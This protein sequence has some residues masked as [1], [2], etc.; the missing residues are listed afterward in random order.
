MSP[1]SWVHWADD[2]AGNEA[3]TRTRHGISAAVPV[4]WPCRTA[5]VGFTPRR[6]K[7]PRRPSRKDAVRM[8]GAPSI[9]AELCFTNATGCVFHS[10]TAWGEVRRRPTHPQSGRCWVEWLSLHDFAATKHEGR[11]RFSSGRGGSKKKSGPPCSGRPR[12]NQ[13]PNLNACWYDASLVALS[14]V[15]T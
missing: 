7:T 13:Y 12:S 15:E 9:S 11:V 10:C 1:P 4:R 14:T 6:K 2:T 3:V 5:P 8:A